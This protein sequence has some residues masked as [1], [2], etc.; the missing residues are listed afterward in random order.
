MILVLSNFLNLFGLTRDEG[1]AAIFSSE[2]MVKISPFQVASVNVFTEYFNRLQRNVSVT[3]KRISALFTFE[4]KYPLYIERRIRS[5]Y[6]A[7]KKKRNTR[8]RA[9]RCAAK[10]HRT[11]E[12]SLE[13]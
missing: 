3:V 5:V 2:A 1:K 6:S 13:I 8:N 9:T 10:F 4:E 7:R 12:I 11:N